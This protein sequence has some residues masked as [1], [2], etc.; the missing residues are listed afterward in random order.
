MCMRSF[1]NMPVLQSIEVRYLTLVKI[2]KWNFYIEIYK[3]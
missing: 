3:R 2:F 1:N